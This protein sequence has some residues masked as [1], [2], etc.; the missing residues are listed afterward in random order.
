MMRAADVCLHHITRVVRNHHFDY[1]SWKG[2]VPLSAACCSCYTLYVFSYVYIYS[3]TVHVMYAHTHNDV[4]SKWVTNATRKRNRL[5]DS[6]R[7]VHARYR[8]RGCKCLSLQDVQGHVL[9]SL[10]SDDTAYLT[11]ITAVIDARHPRSPQFTVQD[12]DNWQID[13]W[14]ISDVHTRVRAKCQ[15]HAHHCDSINL[16]VYKIQID[17]ES[18]ILWQSLQKK[19]TTWYIANKYLNTVK[20]FFF[21]FLGSA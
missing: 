16:W 11:F 14:H 1:S 3:Y 18:R 6:V 9:F 5:S 19:K 15:S 21:F 10:Y 12:F 17:N 8:R 13:T 4:N 2:N 7:T 20:P